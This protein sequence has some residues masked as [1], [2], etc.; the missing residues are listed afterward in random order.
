L[1]KLID[2]ELGTTC[3]CEQTGLTSATASI[4]VRASYTTTTTTTTTTA[5]AH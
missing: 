4:E 3:N 1:Q 2:R 5:D